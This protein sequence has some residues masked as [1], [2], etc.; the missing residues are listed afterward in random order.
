VPAIDVN[1]RKE[2]L[3]RSAIAMGALTLGGTARA[4]TALGDASTSSAQF[5]PAKVATQLSWIKNVQFA[6]WWYAL[7]AGLYKQAAISPQFFSGEQAP[8]F[9]DVIDAIAAGSDFVVFGAQYQD[10]PTGLLSLPKNPIR[11]PHDMLGKRI[12]VQ[13]DARQFQTIMKLAGLPANGFTPVKVGFD[14]APL[15]QGDIDGYSCLVT[16]QAIA[17]QMQGLHPVAVTLGD[18]GFRQYGDVLICKRS[19]LESHRNIVVRWLRAT[20][21]GWELNNKHLQQGTDYSLKIGSN[22]GLDPK[23][24][25]LQNKAQKPLME[26][27]TTRKKGLFWLS[28]EEVAGPIYRALK[29]SGRSDLPP[30]ESFVDLTVLRD[31]FA[32]KKTLTG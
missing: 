24:Q 30:F 11:T 27:V 32:G 26:S 20:I 14:P 4:A 28:K 19:Y 5:S 22:L 18:L 10:N 17:L 12:G 31:V 25:L 29:A 21:K 13:T 1:T 8:F 16:N 6:G 2:F 15:I 3:R 23:Q 9:E 7:E